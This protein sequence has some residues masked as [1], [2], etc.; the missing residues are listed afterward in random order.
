[1]ICFVNKTACLFRVN[2]CVPLNWV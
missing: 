1:M 2:E